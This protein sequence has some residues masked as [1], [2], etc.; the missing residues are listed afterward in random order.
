I[1]RIIIENGAYFLFNLYGIFAALSIIFNGFV[2]LIVIQTF[3]SV[4]QLMLD[5]PFICA[6]ITFVRL[7]QADKLLFKILNT[8]S[9]FAHCKSFKIFRNGLLKNLTTC[10]RDL[11]KFY[12]FHCLCRKSVFSQNQIFGTQMFQSLLIY[13]P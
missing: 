6:L 3:T 9:R 12:H 5:L 7:K 13:T 4:Y 11:N 10:Q 8:K 1:F 2:Y